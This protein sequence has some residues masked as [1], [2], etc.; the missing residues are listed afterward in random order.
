MIIGR[1]RFR[2]GKGV[3]FRRVIEID[4]KFII[5]VVIFYVC[6]EKKGRIIWF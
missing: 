1:I 2:D 6:R 4:I 3:I 5:G